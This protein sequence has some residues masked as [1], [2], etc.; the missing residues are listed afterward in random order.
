[1]VRRPLENGDPYWI[2][3]YVDGYGSV[4][5]RVQ[6][7]SAYGDTLTHTDAE[8]LSGRVFRWNCWEQ[9]FH[10]VRHGSDRLS[11]DDR[12]SVIDILERDGFKDVDVDE[13]RNQKRYD[14]SQRI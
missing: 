12:V 7:Y 5:Y 10:G 8:R 4:H 13:D 3:G 14:C 9:E 1:M 2:L 11:E 6:Y